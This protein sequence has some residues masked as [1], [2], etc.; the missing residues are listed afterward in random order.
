MHDPTG[1]P[2]QPTD[3]PTGAAYILLASYYMLL[4]LKSH[5]SSYR[6]VIGL[7]GP[8]PILLPYG[9]RVYGARAGVS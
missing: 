8:Y 5:L 6:I 7:T 3:G 4:G 2:T 9:A 1:G